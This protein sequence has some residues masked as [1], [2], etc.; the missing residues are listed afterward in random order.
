M[1][2]KR[3]GDLFEKLD[4]VMRQRWMQDLMRGERY[5]PNFWSI[6]EY[7]SQSYETRYSRMLRWLL[8][9]NE[10]HG[11]GRFFMLGIVGLAAGDPETGEG[12]SAELR[13]LLERFDEN[14]VPDRDDRA[15]VEAH[16]DHRS[17]GDGKR[18][19]AGGIDVFATSPALQLC[20]AIENKVYSGLILDEGEGTAQTDR[21]SRA[22]R[23]HPEYGRYRHQVF[24]YL[25]GQEPPEQLS[26]DWT[27]ITYDQLQPLLREGYDRLGRTA[28]ADADETVRADH[29]RKIVQDFIYDSQRKF[30]RLPDH[31]A[32]LE[33]FDA[34]RDQIGS[35]LRALG[36]L[37]DESA[38]PTADA[39]SAAEGEALTREFLSRFVHDSG[40][41]L[42]ALKLVFE[43]QRVGVQ[44]KRPN[45][46]SQ[47]AI[48]M[49]FNRIAGTD[50]FDVSKPERFGREPLR[51]RETAVINPLYR[52]L[53][54]TSIRLTRGKG[55]GLH[56]RGGDPD[57]AIYISGDTH[58][59][60]PNDY[61][62]LVLRPDPGTGRQ[63]AQRL[64]GNRI[65]NVNDCAS[66]EEVSARVDVLMQQFEAALQEHA[67][68]VRS[69]LG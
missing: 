14:C 27:A 60:I 3:S 1:V 66:F 40:D 52:E 2:E 61:A 47:Q 35:L 36:E 6:I 56:L 41:A 21:Y 54:V 63:E 5:R 37:D 19:K 67:E 50:H 15:V 22:V 46:G 25:S 9:P 16:L 57:T 58:G 26:A 31:R 51:E 44:D 39:T 20:V 32:D 33:G 4:A 53:G 23:N 64:L 34:H 59:D 7:G 18:Q 68:A 45:P 49:M 8:D 43:S 12:T 30:H 13:D 48:R 28:S 38:G 42:Q 65:V 17:T 10:N 69:A 29:A 55:Q 24:V 62:K 11:L